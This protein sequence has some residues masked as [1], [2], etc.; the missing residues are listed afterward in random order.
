MPLRPVANV[1]WSAA[2]TATISSYAIARQRVREDPPLF[3]A[4]T[5]TWAEVL[6]RGMG[7]RVA[8][9]GAERLDPA[10]TYILMANHRSHVDI[11]TLFCGLPMVPGFLAKAELRRVPLFGRAMEVG[12]HVFI[13]RGP[14]SNALGAFRSAA[15]EVRRGKTIVIFPEG[16]RSPG[17]EIL[18]LKKGAF[19]LAKHARVD[20]VPVGLR[21]TGAILPK[22]GR[23]PRPGRVE[24]HVGDVIPAHEVRQTKLPVLVDRVR[25]ALA[26]LAAVP[27]AAG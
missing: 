12:G 9:F 7:I 14:G 19:L 25:G 2:W 23:S 11:P 15:A 20:M 13:D 22:G 4:H 3:A 1:L 10:R 18:P 27:L 21:G 8:T 17:D 24:V 16:T 5:R 6:C 26:D